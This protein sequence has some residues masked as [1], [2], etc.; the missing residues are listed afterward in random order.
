MVPVVQSAKLLK[1]WGFVVFI[2]F[3][4]LHQFRVLL[5]EFEQTGVTDLSGLGDTGDLCS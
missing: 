5:I 1:G 3:N 4:G 2:L